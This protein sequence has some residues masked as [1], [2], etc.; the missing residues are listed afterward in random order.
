MSE[1]ATAPEA[2][3]VAESTSVPTGGSEANTATLLSGGVDAGSATA[4][5]QSQASSDNPFA[6]LIGADGAFKDGWINDLPGEEYAEVRDTAANYKT[7][8]ALLKGLKDSKA[9]A[10]QRL[11]G[12]VKLPHNES[13]PEEIAAYRQAIGVPENPDGYTFT[14]PEGVEFDDVA[15][16]EFKK[17]AH[18]ANLTP[19]QASRLVQFQAQL[20]SQV[21]EQA[22]R[23]AEQW[24]Q[25][26]SQKLQEAWGNQFNGKKLLAQRA[27]ATFGVPDDHPALNDATIVQALARAGEA[28]SEDKL[29]SGEKLSNG[30][31][32]ES[33]A[34]DIMANPNNRYYRDYHKKDG[35]TE[36]GHAKAVAEHL[37]LMKQAFPD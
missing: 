28:I 22:N 23:D 4:E 17:L 34:D 35:Y 13:T 24:K 19:D 6:S 16:T 36:E 14:A 8:P 37:R 15:V 31:S 33:Q 26:Q 5:T 7:L 29:V 12:M 10:M 20:E 11:D 30:L 3:A 21:A 25:E 2:G 1:T 32:P 9:A 18:E 27:A